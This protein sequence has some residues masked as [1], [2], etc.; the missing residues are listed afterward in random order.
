MR[1]PCTLLGPGETGGQAAR[2]EEGSAWGS[3]RPTTADEPQANARARSSS[4]RVANKMTDVSDAAPAASE[5]ALIDAVM[6][7]WVSEPGLSAKAVH[8]KLSAEAAWVNVTQ[9]EVKKA[10]SKA[11]KRGGGAATRVMDGSECVRVKP[12]NLHDADKEAATASPGLAIITGG[13]PFLQKAWW[14]D[15]GVHK[16]AKTVARFKKA[17]LRDAPGFG[18]SPEQIAHEQTL[19]DTPIIF[20]LGN[21][22]RVALA[23]AVP[24]L[25]NAMR[26]GISSL[27]V[28]R[29]RAIIQTADA[30]NDLKAFDTKDLE[31]ALSAAGLPIPQ[32]DTLVLTIALNLPAVCDAFVYSSPS[33]TVVAWRTTL[34]LDVA[35]LDKAMRTVVV[36]PTAAQRLVSRHVCFFCGASPLSS[37]ISLSLCPECECVAYCCEEHRKLDR[38]IS[39]GLE[40]G[41]K[42]GFT[43]PMGV[44]ITPCH[45]LSVNRV[46]TEATKDI[47]AKMPLESPGK[48]HVSIVRHCCQAEGTPG[49]CPL[50]MGW[51]V[52]PV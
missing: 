20:D 27:S 31:E 38:V 36:K 8:S 48:S 15:K 50:P 17:F 37:S 25:C 29:L 51:D 24:F 16:S 18:L 30:L 26:L 3:A 19:F 35:K 10:C 41:T 28:E 52:N 49:P 44:P 13:S 2:E 22:G 6:Q 14:F 23:P 1:E 4:R 40:C 9:G 34:S 47:S 39:H 45:K 46:V 5:D 33:D 32:A 11:M 43:S 12:D 42:Q 21:S 7:L